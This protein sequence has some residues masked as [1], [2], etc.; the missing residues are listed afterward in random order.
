[1]TP[2]VCGIEPETIALFVETPVPSHVSLLVTPR[3]GG[4]CGCT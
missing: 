4:E 1:M 3:A 2:S